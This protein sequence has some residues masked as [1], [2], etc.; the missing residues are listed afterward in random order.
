MG[1]GGIGVAVGGRRRPAQAI[2]QSS[3]VS[4][5]RHP[6]PR[7]RFDGLAAAI[8]LATSLIPVGAY[9]RLVCYGVV[10]LFALDF[11]L[12]GEYT[13]AWW[14]EARIL[15]SLLV[16]TSMIA[17][18]WIVIREQYRDEH[19]PPSL[20]YVEPGGRL[21]E[22]SRWAFVVRHY[23][24]SSAMNV[25]INFSDG[26]SSQRLR[27]SEIDPTGPV[28]G[29]FLWLPPDINNQRYRA[30]INCRDGQYVENI[31]IRRI[32]GAFLSKTDVSKF[33]RNSPSHPY[34]E[35]DPLFKCDDF[36]NEKE[37][38]GMNESVDGT[39]WNLFIVEHLGDA[40]LP[41][42][43][44]IQPDGRVMTVAILVFASSV[45]M[46]IYCLIA[47]W[48]MGESSRIPFSSFHVSE[49]VAF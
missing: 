18:T 26:K 24:P 17:L 29:V 13:R 35:L 32:N 34:E 41:L 45:L 48:W 43:V 19:L 42:E 28:D 44:S 11:S 39:C 8:S 16:L 10:L 25:D 15:L 12:R 5:P 2:V 22:T 33:I 31:E 36:P 38:M 47:L 49:H 20:A 37:R 40:H 46:P 30:D 21:A 14:P 4:L 23:G 6:H 9:F 7:A 1:T 3:M 27:W